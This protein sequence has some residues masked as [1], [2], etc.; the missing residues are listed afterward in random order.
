MEKE[1]N[2]V[3]KN[4]KNLYIRLNE[5][6]KPVTCSERE[7]GVFEYSKAKN[8]LDNLQ[9]TLK[10]L[11][12]K[13]EP[14]PENIRQKGEEYK[15]VEKKVIYNENYVIPDTI[16][17][18]V[19]KFGICDD[20]LKEA[21]IRKKELIQI[22]SSYDRSISNWL[23]S[24]E[25]EKKKN[26]CAGYKKYSDVKDIVDKR[27]CVKDELMII[28]N[29]LKM[30]FRELD[31]DIVHKTVIGLAKRKFAYRIVEEDETKSVV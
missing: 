21:E 24:V 18:W 17:R 13:V 1:L 7:R 6:G 23:H 15:E 4:Y 31:R 20:I 8:I 5:N 22:I 28:N 26:A 30:D 14:I 16:L 12:F 25:L 11:N 19:E 3:I 29:V 10:K 2:Y 9:K 27:R